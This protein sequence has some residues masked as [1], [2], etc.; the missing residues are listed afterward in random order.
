[1]KVQVFHLFFK[2][3]GAGG[4]TPM[5]GDLH[6]LAVKYVAENVAIPIDFT[7]Y[8]D[9]WI[10]CEVDEEGKP[11]RA[12]GVLGMQVRAD[13]SLCRFTDNAAVMKLVQRANDHL[14][15]VYGARG[16]EVLVHIAKDELPEQRCPNYLDWMKAFDLQPA[17]RWLYKVR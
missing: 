6:A 10:A 4:L 17:D 15:D 1:M 9:S 16:T 8:K 11:V 12:L 2:S 3:D 5:D 14:H 7:A 13:I